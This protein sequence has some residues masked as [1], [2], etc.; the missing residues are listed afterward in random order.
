MDRKRKEKWNTWGSVWG[1]EKKWIG[2]D[3]MK[4]NRKE[5]AILA[6]TFS[7]ESESGKT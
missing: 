6:F 4:E 2:L 3:G 1:L 5:I 7:W